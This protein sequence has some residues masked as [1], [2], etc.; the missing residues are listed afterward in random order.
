ME[1][2]ATIV[3]ICSSATFCFAQHL[4]SSI[5]LAH[6]EDLVGDQYNGFTQSCL[7][8]DSAGNYHHEVR[9]QEHPHGHATAAWGAS[10]VFEGTLDA[11]DLE[12][13]SSIVDSDGF[14][15]I[16]GIVGD[17]DDVS[18]RLVVS[19][20]GIYPH[21]DMEVFAASV[22]RKEG[23][24]VIEIIGDH[25]ETKDAIQPLKKWVA[26]IA[27]KKVKNLG[28]D[29]ADFCAAFGEKNRG[30]KW[31]PITRLRPTVLSAHQP[32]YPLTEQS[33]NR[34]GKVTVRATINPDGTVRQ[35]SI[36]R[37]KSPKLDQVALDAVRKWTF[38][39]TLLYGFAIPSRIDVEVEFRN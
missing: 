31:Q 32:K 35:V 16:T 19:P 10:E 1:R 11:A 2:L 36:V 17:L 27:R 3:L 26:A 28:S 39:P 4:G 13:L 30:S 21:A 18:W 23:A 12:E 22:S 38:T 5:P 9:K 37:G 15:S 29:A 25:P 8:I 33:A 7:L 34:E 24:K 20:D 14:G 6:V